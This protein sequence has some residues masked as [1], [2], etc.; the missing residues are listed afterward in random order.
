MPYI[1]LLDSTVIY[2]KDMQKTG[3]YGYSFDAVVEELLLRG[4]REAIDKKYIEP[5]AFPDV[6]GDDLQNEPCK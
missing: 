6:E 5:R 3:L 1:S 2:L 4:V